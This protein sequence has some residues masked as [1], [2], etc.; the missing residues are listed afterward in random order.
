MTVPS[1]ENSAQSS[2]QEQQA[3]A[4]KYEANDIP[5][6]IAK[7]N[8]F[9]AK[10]IIDI[11]KAAEIPIHQDKHMAKALSALEINQAIPKELFAAVAQVLVFAYNLR[12]DKAP[13]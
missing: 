11:A 9:M 1:S 4:L 12:P 5:R 10:R 2:P 8:G 6:V 13:K 3:V 7:A